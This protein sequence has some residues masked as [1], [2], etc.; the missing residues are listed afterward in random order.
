MGRSDDAVARAVDELSLALG[1]GTPEDEDKVFALGGETADCS[2]GKCLPAA[3]LM[4]GGGAGVD[5]ECGVEQQDTL[6]GPRAEVARGWRGQP[7][8]SSS[9][10]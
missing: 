5:G 6:T 4:R 7:R 9:S 3:V 1:I 10:L 8:S 2:V